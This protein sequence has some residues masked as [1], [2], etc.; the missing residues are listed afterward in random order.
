MDKLK[1]NEDYFK[2]INEEKEFD[3]FE[4]ELDSNI[5][6]LNLDKKDENNLVKFDAYF[7]FKIND[8]KEYIFPIKSD[9]F[10]INDRHVYE[11]IKN[12]IKKINEKHIIINY[13]DIKYIISLK[14]LEN[15]NDIEFYIKN[16]EFKPCKKKNFMPKNDSPSYSSNSLL[17]NI[18][19]KFLSFVSKS[20]LNIMLIE[21]FETNE[22]EGNNKYQFDDDEDY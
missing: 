7:Y 3:E 2:G 22:N 16:Y 5:K 14:D 4:K 20:P 19:K 17:K 8:E 6:D 9:L 21:Q 12:I 11:L 18:D 1:D 15:E 13:N 10:N